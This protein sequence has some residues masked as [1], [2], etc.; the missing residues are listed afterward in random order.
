MKSRLPTTPM[1]S[2]SLSGAVAVIVK[3][4]HFCARVFGF[5]NTPAKKAAA[6]FEDMT[7]VDK[8]YWG[9]K[10]K[11]PVARPEKGMDI[12]IFSRTPEKDLALPDGFELE[13]SLTFAALG[14]L[15]KVDGLENSKNTL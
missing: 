4:V 15:I 14:D 1:E 8:I 10:S 5:W 12:S 7:L 6:D 9:Y 13:N 11:H 2:L 3:I